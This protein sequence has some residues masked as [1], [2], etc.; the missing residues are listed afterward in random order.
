MNESLEIVLKEGEKENQQILTLSK[1]IDLNHSI[2]ETSL[3][4]LQNEELEDN[5]NGVVYE[6]YLKNL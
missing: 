4:T 3:E 5:Y 1:P 2:F 6:D